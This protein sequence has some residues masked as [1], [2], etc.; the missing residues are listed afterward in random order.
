[1]TPKYRLRWYDR[2]PCIII[3]YPRWSMDGLQPGSFG[4]TQPLG[5]AVMRKGATGT[6]GPPVE[7]L[8]ND[9]A[10]YLKRGTKTRTGTGAPGDSKAAP[11]AGGGCANNNRGAFTYPGERCEDRNACVL[12]SCSSTRAVLIFVL[13]VRR[14]S[15]GVSFV[16][17]PTEILVGMICIST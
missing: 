1:M 10:K 17:I 7:A 12:C 13:F 5:A 16:P 4:T 14:D 6:F 11:S 3:W 2:S 9:P 8:R 15:G